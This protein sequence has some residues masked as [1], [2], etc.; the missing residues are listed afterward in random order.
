[1]KLAVLIVEDEYLVAFDYCQTVEDLG[2]RVVGPVATVA[3]ALELIERKVP[4]LA[5]LDLRLAGAPVTPVA[6]ALHDMDIPFI[7]VS[8]DPAL[9]AGS[10]EVFA[11]VT[12]VVKPFSSEII[13][14]ALIDAMAGRNSSTPK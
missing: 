13:R 6:R 8:G 11:G 10:D 9:P 2:W 12:I 1:M 14:Q 3:E 5:V 4:D 7:V